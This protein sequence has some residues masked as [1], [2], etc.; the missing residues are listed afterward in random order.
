MFSFE[1][2]F[3]QILYKSLQFV[4]TFDRNSTFFVVWPEMSSNSNTALFIHEIPIHVK[5]DE[6]RQRFQAYGKIAN[7]SIHKKN[8]KSSSVKIL[9]STHEEAQR[10][11]EGSR[12]LTLGGRSDIK[13]A[14]NQ[15]QPHRYYNNQNNNNPERENTSLA[16]TGLPPSNLPAHARDASLREFFSFLAPETVRIT[17][18][19]L[20][21]LT[22]QNG[23]T[24]ADAL[25]KINSS[26]LQFEGHP[27]KADFFHY[28]SNNPNN[29]NWSLPR[30]VLYTTKDLSSA[31]INE[32]IYATQKIKDGALL[33][34][35]SQ[36]NCEAF[37]KLHQQNS[38]MNSQNNTQINTQNNPAGTNP[39]NIQFNNQHTNNQYGNTSPYNSSQ[40]YSKAKTD[41]VNEAF[42]QLEK[43]TIYA[44]G[45]KDA[46]DH[47]NDILTLFQSKGKVIK[48]DVHNTR[49]V[50]VQYETEEAR[51][52]AFELNHHVFQNTQS[53]LT[54]LPYVEKRLQHR[55][56]GLVQINE[57]PPTITVSELS[58]E[59]KQF[60]KVL[61]SSI[62][63]TGFDENPYGF[64]LFESYEDAFEAKRI[65]SSKYP[66]IFLYPPMKAAEAIF[67]FTEQQN[68][69]PNN[70]LVIYDLPSSAQ[71]PEIHAMVKGFGF[72][73][74]SYVLSDN[75]KSKAAYIYYTKPEDAVSAYIEMSKQNKKCDLLNGNVLESSIHTLKV[76]ALPRS[77][78]YRLLFVQG[79]P[80]FDFGTSNLRNQLLQFGANIESCFV[81]LY[82]PTGLPS[83]HAII[84]TREH[85]S[86]V[87][88]SNMLPQLIKGILVNYYESTGGYTQPDLQPSAGKTEQK[89]QIP[90]GNQ[91]ITPR[92][93][94]KQFAGL[95]F[96][97]FKQQIALTVD[98]MSI[99]DTHGLL[100]DYGSF[101]NWI[102]GEIAKMKA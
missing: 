28:K 14:W 95:N 5:E 89:Y 70:C 69:A 59:F 65:S 81:R 27:L 42:R 79:L 23:A 16:I 49:A 73:K 50:I 54:I 66:N 102:E 41:V 32:H 100:N 83:G 91:K 1:G 24:A 96:P 67:A 18:N 43:R 33:F 94:I 63:P 7:I 99:K 90:P 3:N 93:W 17:K 74:S 44:D 60:G 77:W 82:P 19:N 78:A 39:V 87:M 84:L 20:C 38:Q 11:L 53:P 36:E 34:F 4:I 6:V 21:I 26:Q 13:I 8:D 71:E 92:E 64:V 85:Q 30:S 22:F 46:G 51:E 72:I 31:D 97:E 57:F 25:R 9:F 88:I 55:E 45:F 10:A 48:L 2:K 47:R 61:A 75:N 56:A 68:S 35:D 15:P 76:T 98:R 29:E 37:M 101:I 86:S 62:A 58:E 52:S 40:V 80:Q 12:G